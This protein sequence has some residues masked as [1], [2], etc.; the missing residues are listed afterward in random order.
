MADTEVGTGYFGKGFIIDLDTSTA[1]SSSYSD[2]GVS[3][4]RTAT[5]KVAITNRGS[6]GQNVTKYLEVTYLRT[7]RVYWREVR[8]FNLV[9]Q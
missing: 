4:S 8:D 9:S 3:G 2:R 5:K 7:G 1:S 6:T